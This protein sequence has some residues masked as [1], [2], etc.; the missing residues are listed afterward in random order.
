MLKYLTTCTPESPVFAHFVVG[1]REG[2]AG[3]VRFF[4]FFWDWDVGTMFPVC[5]HKVANAVPIDVPS[6]AFGNQVPIATGMHDNLIY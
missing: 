4:F 2:G 1:G 5:S 6:V 3:G